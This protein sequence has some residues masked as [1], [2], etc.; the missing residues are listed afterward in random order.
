MGNGVGLKGTTDALEVRAERLRVQ[1]QLL[2]DF[3]IVKR[4]ALLCP[5][6][7]SHYKL[8]SRIHGFNISAVAAFEVRS[9]RLRVQ[10]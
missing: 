9:Q 1:I 5:G 4:S 2:P 3:L 8:P 6:W 10:I 7:D